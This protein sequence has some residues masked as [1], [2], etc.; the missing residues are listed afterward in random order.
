VCNAGTVVRLHCVVVNMC[1]II[2]DYG[3]PLLVSLELDQSLQLQNKV[4]SIMKVYIA[5]ATTDT[6]FC[7]ITTALASNSSADRAQLICASYLWS[8]TVAHSSPLVTVRL[9]SQCPLCC[10][11]N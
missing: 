3:Y 4:Y 9:H 1:L 5:T 2:I 7:T 11:V 6:A 8:R 10:N